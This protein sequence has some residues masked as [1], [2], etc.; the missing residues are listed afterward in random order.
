[1]NALTRTAAM[2]LAVTAAAV[3]QA[4]A[5]LRYGIRLGGE[6][7]TARLADAP[8]W[9]IKRGSGFS[10]GLT[11]EYQFEASGFA[12]DASLLY[13]HSPL[14]VGNASG[15]WKA[16]N[17]MLHIPLH[18]KY[19]HWLRSAYD[20]AAPFVYTGPSLMVRLDSDDGGITCPTRRVQ[21]GW[22]I[23]AGF[24]ILNF[25]QVSAGY[26]FGLGS[27]VRSGSKSEGISLRRDGVEVSVTLLFDI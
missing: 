25:I 14:T 23:G 22:D 27:I 15:S 26:R 19:K 12:L 21:P 4:A 2:L 18:A 9:D 16:G 11:C 8:E 6:I 7:S 10:G 20:L 3:P 5:Q 24:D 17:D 13:T 1:M